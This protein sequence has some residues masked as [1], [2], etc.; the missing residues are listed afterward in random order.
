MPHRRFRVHSPCDACKPISSTKSLRVTGKVPVGTGV[1]SVS[2]LTGRESG[3]LVSP[4]GSER[5][6][7]DLIGIGLKLDG[8]GDLL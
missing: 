1:S 6:R 2:L 8:E 7:E 3:E 5:G 4:A